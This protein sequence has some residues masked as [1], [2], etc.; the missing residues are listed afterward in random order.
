MVKA[1]NNISTLS[2][3]T[4]LIADGGCHQ[5]L[6]TKDWDVSSHTSKEVTM[7]GAFAGR[8]IGQTFPVVSVICKLTDEKGNSYAGL[9]C[10]ALYDDSDAQTE[11]LLSV[12][13]SLSFQKDGIDDRSR[14]ENDIHGKPGKQ[15]AK[16]GDNTLKFYFDGSKCY[17]KVSEITEEEK[18]SLDIVVLTAPNECA[19]R[20]RVYPRNVTRKDKDNGFWK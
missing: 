5:T 4:I 16:F 11:S 20:N 3:S 18:K 10:E 9:V 19:S 12:H 1:I 8:S 7:V 2:S 15:C 6:I 17:F 14:T 13:Q